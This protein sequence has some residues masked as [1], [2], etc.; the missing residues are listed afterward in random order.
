MIIDNLD[1]FITRTNTKKYVKGTNFIVDGNE[2]LFQVKAGVVFNTVISEEGISSVENEVPVEGV[3]E[4]TS[5]RLVKQDDGV[6]TIFCSDGSK[7]IAILS[8]NTGTHSLTNRQIVGPIEEINW[9]KTV[10]PDY[11]K[12]HNA[13]YAISADGKLVWT[14][15]GVNAT[16]IGSVV[17]LTSEETNIAEGSIAYGI[18]SSETE[19]FTTYSINPAATGITISRYT[20][21]NGGFIGEHISD[22]FLKISVEVVPGSFIYS[23]GNS[24]IIAYNGTNFTYI[25]G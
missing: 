11:D 4:D 13:I 9:D 21:N 14:F 5:M 15:R 22:V 24:I 25:I 7:L 10:F 6:I 23:R 2:I 8:Y 12:S 17:T 19:Y 16:S 18:C 3:T 20:K 1:Q